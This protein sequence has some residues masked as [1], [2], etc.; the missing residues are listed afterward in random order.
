MRVMSCSNLCC[1]SQCGIIH[2]R[3][4]KPVEERLAEG[5]RYAAVADI[6][7]QRHN[8]WEAVEVLYDMRFL[9]ITLYTL[10]HGDQRPV[11]FFQATA[12][13]DMQT[14]RVTRCRRIV[15]YPCKQHLGAASIYWRTIWGL[16][17]MSKSNCRT[18]ITQC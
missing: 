5:V 4:P 13:P 11:Q 10:T 1:R 7:L 14:Q 8:L 16:S 12:V 17:R 18:L 9:L 3:P 15:S 2:W 6:A